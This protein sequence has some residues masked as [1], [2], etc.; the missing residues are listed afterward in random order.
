MSSHL[1]KINTAAIFLLMF[2]II[3]TA[4]SQFYGQSLWLILTVVGLTI[5]KGQ[6]ITDVFMELKNAPAKW[7][8]ML[9]GYA[10]LLPVIIGVIVYI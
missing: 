1:R 4:L 8:Y 5:I 2:T 10:V 3:S 6:Q 7:R 9:L